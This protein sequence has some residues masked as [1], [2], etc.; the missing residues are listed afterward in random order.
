MFISALCTYAFPLFPAYKCLCTA[1]YFL[2]ARILF[3]SVS[4]Q[5]CPFLAPALK[6]GRKC[7]KFFHG[8]GIK[9][10]AHR[11]RRLIPRR[12]YLIFW[13]LLLPP[14]RPHGEDIN[15]CC[16][17]RSWRLFLSNTLDLN[18]VCI[19]SGRCCRPHGV[20]VLLLLL[21]WLLVFL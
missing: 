17:F 13:A 4:I 3:L 6:S 10:A 15:G 16:R 9:C 7:A 19:C 14:L 21:L 1:L 5:G 11:T 2:F 20:V 12:K 8:I 18:I